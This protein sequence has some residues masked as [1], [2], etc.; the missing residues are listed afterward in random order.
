MLAQL[1]FGLCYQCIPASCLQYYL[2]LVYQG[3]ALRF[4]FHFCCKRLCCH[5][6]GI[7]DPLEPFQG[8]DR[9]VP[10]TFL[11]LQLGHPIQ[12]FSGIL[13][14]HSWLRKVVLIG[15]CVD[16]LFQTLTRL[17]QKFYVLRIWNVLRCTCGIQNQCTLVFLGCLSSFGKFS[18][19]AIV[20]TFAALTFVIWGGW[21]TG[22]VVLYNHF[23]DF[24]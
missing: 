1:R 18:C 20:L 13:A 8:N 21:V 16:N 5:D 9:C 24:P 17:I 23:I 4:V 10:C 12:I 7:S 3:P 6:F 11:L 15:N 22:G 14:V 2:S 19:F